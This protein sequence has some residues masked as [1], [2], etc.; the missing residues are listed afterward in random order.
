MQYTTLGNSNLRISKITLGTMTFGQ[1]NNQ[2]EADAQ[3]D[4]AISCGINTIDTAEMYPVPPRAETVH[5]T[6]TMVGNWLARCA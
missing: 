5:R 1:Q 6:E 2:A 3:L 4:Y